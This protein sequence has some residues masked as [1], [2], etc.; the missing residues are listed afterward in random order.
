MDTEQIRR[1]IL[2]APG[3]RG[4]PSFPEDVQRMRT[5]EDL[6]WWLGTTTFAR[7]EGA[8]EAITELALIQYRFDPSHKGL[9][10]LLSFILN[11]DTP[12][13]LEA[14]EG[15]VRSEFPPDKQET[16]HSTSDAIRHAVR[17]RPHMRKAVAQYIIFE[18]LGIYDTVTL[19][20]IA[21]QVEREYRWEFGDEAFASSTR[22]ASAALAG[23]SYTEWELVRKMLTHA[24]EIG[25]HH[26]RSRLA[27]NWLAQVRLR[28][29]DLQKRLDQLKQMSMKQIWRQQMVYTTADPEFKD[30][31]F[32]GEMFKN[33]HN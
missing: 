12:G 18:Y 26:I 28:D 22:N 17:E 27:I 33:Q 13:Y 4:T 29:P 7:R 6:L 25:T 15:A 1:E 10:R 31:L 11:L 20:Q 21:E 5:A 19:A 24:L 2:T 23:T 30:V 14:G 8:Y 9:M 16:I 32:R 3:Y